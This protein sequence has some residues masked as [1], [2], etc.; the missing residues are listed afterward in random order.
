VSKEDYAKVLISAPSRLVILLVAFIF[1]S[2]GVDVIRGPG[3]DLGANQQKLDACLVALDDSRSIASRYEAD[4]SE[5]SSWAASAVDALP[6]IQRLG[7]LDRAPD[8][9]AFAGGTISQ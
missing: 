2:A 3:I 9:F 1:G 7:A 8:A 6:T 5:L 4:I